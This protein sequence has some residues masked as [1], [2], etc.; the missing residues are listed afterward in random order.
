M[1]SSSQLRESSPP[2]YQEALHFVNSIDS[3]SEAGQVPEIV[4]CDEPLPPYTGRQT[5]EQEDPF[6]PSLE[7]AET[8]F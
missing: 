4:V 2:S 7:N 8:S 5:D 3:C 6:E 1:S